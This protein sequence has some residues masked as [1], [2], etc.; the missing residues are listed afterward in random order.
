MTHDEILKVIMRSK[1]N[2]G[3]S[4]FQE[5]LVNALRHAIDRER[6]VTFLLKCLAVA[7][8]RGRQDELASMQRSAHMQERDA[9]A[10]QHLIL[11]GD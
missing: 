7:Y 6:P 1:L 2:L 10:L 5:E 9:V 3:V 4:V 8:H 11:K